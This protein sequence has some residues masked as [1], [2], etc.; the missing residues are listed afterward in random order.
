MAQHVPPSVFKEALE[1]GKYKLIDVR[2]KEEYAQGHIKNAIQKDYY[3]TQEFL[4]FLNSLDKNGKYLIYC[5]TDKRSSKTL[6]IM[7]EKGFK[8][9]SDMTGG[10]N[11][12]VTLGY[13]TEK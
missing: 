8:N 12:W 7:K 2:T 10:Y 9:V 6:E 1:S 5:R 13:P 4:G 3:K 11:G